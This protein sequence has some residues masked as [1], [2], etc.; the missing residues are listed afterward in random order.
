MEALGDE[1]I[2]IIAICMME[3]IGKTTMAKEVARR[4]KE[5]KLI[6]EVVMAIGAQN[7]NVM[8]IQGEIADALG[9][10][11]NME[12]VLGRAGELLRT[13]ESIEIFFYY[14]G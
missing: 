10:K 6:G 5:E 11:F 7:P 8:K 1:N 4:A 14:T 3:G 9:L 12:T 2:N 13:I